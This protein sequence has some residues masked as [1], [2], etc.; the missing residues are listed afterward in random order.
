MFFTFI[1]FYLFLPFV[2]FIL[3][4]LCNYLEVNSFYT[5]PGS[6]QIPRSH[7]KL[8]LFEFFF[9]FAQNKF[10]PNLIT[11]TEQ[12]YKRIYGFSCRQ[13]FN[14]FITQFKIEYLKSNTDI[15]NLK[16]AVSPIH[17]TSFRNI[18]EE[19]FTDDQ[20]YI[21]DMDK[22]YQKIIISENFKNVNFDLIIITHLW[23]KKFDLSKLKSITNKDTIVI[24]D[25]VLGGKLKDKYEF[26]SDVYF[27]SCGMDKKPAS[28]FGGFVDVKNDKVFNLINNNLYNLEPVENKVL[29]N[30]IFD[31]LLL[32]FIY[33][34][35]IINNLIKLFIKFSG[36]KLSNITQR[37]RESKPGFDHSNY[38]IKPNKIMIN[39]LQKIDNDLE[40]K[41]DKQEN[42]FIKKNNLF[43]NNFD[44]NEKSEYF[45][46]YE[47]NINST[48][49]R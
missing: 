31:I 6:I 28:L 18:I 36:H 8:L 13:L 41:V 22:N 4:K 45:P 2:N 37:I 23:G 7:F 27:H 5:V 33:N 25:S 40:I 26:N 10:Y 16:I 30:K 15:K 29:F 35:K 42:L 1:F 34:Y 38:M 3:I 44:E 43:I 47:N 48:S 46:W 14:S 21:L 49:R 11:R 17:H 24:E 39:F 20:I 9:S 19:N 32:N 12:E